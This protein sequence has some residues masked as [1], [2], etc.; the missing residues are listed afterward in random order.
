MEARFSLTDSGGVSKEAH[1]LEV[2][3]ITMRDDTE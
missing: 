2:S 3:C 1:F